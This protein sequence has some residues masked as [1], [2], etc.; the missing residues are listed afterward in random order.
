[1]L[2]RVYQSATKLD[3]HGIGLS[4]VVQRPDRV[5]YP[6][7]TVCVRDS[8]ADRFKGADYYSP[9]HGKVYE[10]FVFCVQLGI[11]DLSEFTST[12]TATRCS[13]STSTSSPPT[14][15]TTTSCTG[16]SRST[17]P[18]RC[19][20]DSSTWYFP[21]T[22]LS[23]QSSLGNAGDPLPG[24]EARL[25]LGCGHLPPQQ[26]PGDILF[27]VRF[28]RKSTSFPQMYIPNLSHLF[29]SASYGIRLNDNKNWTGLRQSFKMSLVKWEALDLPQSRCKESLCQATLIRSDLRNREGVIRLMRN[30]TYS[31]ASGSMC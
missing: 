7:I 21:S 10:I 8:F 3:K 25:Y 13:R 17:L 30:R 15:P 20:P 4:E 24:R 5:L 11:E 18:D 22:M 14:T 9:E 31:P 23:S 12:P 2:F 6:S 19:P 16:A 1:M 27:K 29:G 28:F 26:E